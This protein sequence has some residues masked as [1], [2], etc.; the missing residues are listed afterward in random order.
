MLQERFVTPKQTT[1]EASL[2]RKIILPIF[3]CGVLFL[4]IGIAI[5]LMW[6]FP[7]RPFP[8]AMAKIFFT[9]FFALSLFGGL[10]ALLSAWNSQR[11]IHADKAE[12]RWRQWGVW[13]ESTWDQVTDYGR[14]ETVLE[15][16]V[17]RFQDGKEL[18]FNDDWRHVDSLKNA[19]I[20]QSTRAKAGGVWLD[21]GARPCEWPARFSYKTI[22]KGNILI[23]KKLRL[24]MF[25][26][27]IFC[28]AITCFGYF[29]ALIVTAQVRLLQA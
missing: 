25:L 28:I 22:P 8:E 10:L 3:A 5:G 11:K 15:S 27:A 17:V 16:N 18:R 13:Q 2:D 6:Q 1:V 9:N 19:I 20:Q 24:G 12:L 26:W 23:A 21:I 4:G 29:N 14:D 7:K